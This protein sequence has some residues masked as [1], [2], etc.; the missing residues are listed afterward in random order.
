MKSPSDELVEMIAP[1]LVDRGL[2][3]PADVENYKSQIAAG[4]MK[5]EDWF[6]AAEKALEKGVNQ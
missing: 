3:L 4:T 2:L 5:A 6:L 1:L